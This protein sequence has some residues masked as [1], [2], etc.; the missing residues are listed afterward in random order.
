MPKK[1]VSPNVAIAIKKL[2]WSGNK[3]GA[4]GLIS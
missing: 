1:N 2:N 3:N 4:I